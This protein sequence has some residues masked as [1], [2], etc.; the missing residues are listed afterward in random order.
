MQRLNALAQSLTGVVGWRELAGDAV[1]GDALT[2][3]LKE[4]RSGLYVNDLNEL[5]RLQVLQHVKPVG[6]TLTGWLARVQADALTKV[7]ARLLQEQGLS[8]QTL[9]SDASLGKGPGRAGDT[10]N[11]LS[12]FVG[13]QLRLRAY[14]GVTFTVPQISLQLNQVPAQPVP[15]YV[16]RSDEPDPV[17]TIDVTVTRANWPAVVPLTG[18]DLLD[19]SYGMETVLYIGYY[20]DDLGDAAA[21]SRE[22]SHL[23]CGCAGYDPYQEWKDYAWPR[24]ISVPESAFGTEGELFDTV[25]VQ[26]ENNTFGLN[27][28]LSAYCNVAAALG[29]EENQLRVAECLQLA[30]GI[31]LLEGIIGTPNI[32]QVTQRED[33]Q[34]DAMA[35]LFN[36]QAR[37]YG[38]KEQGT[39]NYYP[40]LLKK[41]QLDLS[42]LD[43]KC[44]TPKVDRISAAKL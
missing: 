4:S 41:V 8:G 34:A 29:T 33:I 35:L 40:S 11:K 25:A 14:E 43:A 15:V 12:R 19:I 16:Y 22:F 38:G 1:S 24:S 28:H 2:T 42:G 31:R 10:V 23:P 26:L 5:T 20:E 36:Y 37:L 17:K 44:Q 30:M 27:L 7:A 21:I 9:L 39:E 6:E 13:Y 18:D 3:E 32:T